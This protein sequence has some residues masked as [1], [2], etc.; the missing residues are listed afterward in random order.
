MDHLLNALDSFRCYK[1]KDIENFLRTRSFDFLDHKLCSIYLIVD[2]QLF[3]DGIIKIDAYFTLSHKTLISEGISRTKIQKVTGGIKNATSLHFVLIGQLGK[4][5]KLLENNT[6]IASAISAPE[7]LDRAFEIIQAS[8]NL[9]PCRFVLVE[10]KDD[11]KV[12]NIY[13]SYEFKLFQYDGKHYQ[14]YKKI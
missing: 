9:I 13:E 1:D 2:E 11:P 14:Y 8:S 10:C 3:D 7:I 6:V 12:R 4:Y 5:M